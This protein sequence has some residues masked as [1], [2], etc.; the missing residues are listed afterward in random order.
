MLLLALFMSVAQCG[1]GGSSPQVQQV[2]TV[3]NYLLNLLIF[4]FWVLTD[5]ACLTIGWFGILF[6][7]DAGSLY[8]ECQFK[9]IDMFT[10][11]D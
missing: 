1:G 9:L 5:S 10:M 6:A 2:S 11:K 4:Q 8:N 3:G 7:N